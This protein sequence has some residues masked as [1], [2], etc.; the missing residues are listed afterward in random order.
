MIM[1]GEESP[2]KQRA[3][4][5]EIERT[6]RTLVKTRTDVVNVVVITDNRDQRTKQGANGRC[7]KVI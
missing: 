3:K 2:Q 6:L 1:I 4:D 7:V 5:T